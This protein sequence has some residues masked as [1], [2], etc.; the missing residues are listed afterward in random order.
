MG[1]LVMMK[2][3][4]SFSTSQINLL[5]TLTH[6]IKI[7]V[8]NARNY[9]RAVTDDL[10][11]LYTR[12]FFEMELEREIEQSNRASRPLSLAMIDIDDF[13]DYNDTFGHPEGDAVLERLAEVFR[14][15]VR[16]SDIREASRKTDT[17]ARYGG[18]EFAIILPDTDRDGARRV[19]ERIVDRVANL[20][21]FK[22]QVTVSI[23]VAEHRDGESREAFLK[24]TDNALYEAKNQGKNRTLTG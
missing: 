15:E 21:E 17:V 7:A 8:Q 12:R 18:E 3:N 19:A 10:T 4:D 22:R 20:D 5:Q 14:D 11:G 23:G 9:Q 2:E 13:K 16:T 6:Q 1:Y 24:R